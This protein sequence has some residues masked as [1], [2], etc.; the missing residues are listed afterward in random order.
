MQKLHVG[1]YAILEQNKAILLIKKRRGPYAS[2][3]DLPGGRPEHGE[4]IEETLRREVLEETGIQVLT[5]E[6]FLN[7]SFSVDYE[8]M[9]KPISLHHI[10]LIYK[11]T[12]FNDSDFKGNILAE[13]VSGA[14]WILKSHLTHLPL[15]KVVETVMV[16]QC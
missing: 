16:K 14:E 3:Y 11:V 13:D 6:P 8:E 15:S 1:I 12:Q 9:G 5:F 4:S 10:A 7:T 2:M